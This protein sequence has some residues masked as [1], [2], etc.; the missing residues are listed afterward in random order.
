M[1]QAEWGWAGIKN[2]G[3]QG[4]WVKPRPLLINIVVVIESWSP[5]RRTVVGPSWGQELIL[6]LRRRL[7]RQLGTGREQ[8]E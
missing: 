7:Q 1:G 5:C 2:M 6:R 4:G 8:R 3:D